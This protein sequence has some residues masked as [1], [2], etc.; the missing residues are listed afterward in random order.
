MRHRMLISVLVVLVLVSALPVSAQATNLLQDPGFE[1]EGYT[2][3]TADPADPYTTF[4][5]PYSWWGGLVAGGGGAAWINVYPNGFPH[6]GPIKR[7]GNRSYNLGRGGGTFTAWI[8]QQVSVQPNTNVE[9]GAWVYIH[10]NS[11]GSIV[12]AGIDPTGGTD[13]N[14]PTVVWGNASGGLYQWNYVTAATKA[15][16]AGV[17]TLFLYATQTAP[18]D[19][20]S[21][22]W[23]DA[24]LNGIPGPG[25]SSAPAAAAS[26]PV[27][28]RVATSQVRVNVRGGAGTT[29]PRIGALNPGETYAVTGDSGGWYS[30]D[31]NGQTGWVSSAF[32]TVTEGTP[33][34]GAVSVGAAPT[35]NALNFTVDYALRLRA[36]P[37]TTSATLGNIAFNTVVSAVGRSANAQ[38]VQVNYNGVTGWI[39]ARYGRAD[40]DITGLPITG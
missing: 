21:V 32:V 20:N 23:D 1:G 26:A 29:F 4:N 33:S 19:P 15:G 8:S 38:W 16:A 7:S 5:V 24:F 17:V 18:S 39:S 9:G 35:V 10:S 22:Y 25:L 31:F 12:R 3:I 11:G 30:L 14:S 2:R 6:T 40:G 28:T 27:V 37:N 34:G 36:E 13:A